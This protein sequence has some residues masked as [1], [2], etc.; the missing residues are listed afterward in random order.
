MSA[1]RLRKILDDQFTGDLEAMATVLRISVRVLKGMLDGT[2]PI[3]EWVWERL[4]PK[5]KAP[6]R[7]TRTSRKFP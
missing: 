2:I 6:R 5:P 3:P 7:T 4:E 1:E